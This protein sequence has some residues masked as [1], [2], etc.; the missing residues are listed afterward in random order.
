M[1]EHSLLHPTM[2]DRDIP[3]G[4]EILK[5]YNVAM[6]CVKSY[7]IPLA[8][9][10]LAGTDVKV[11]PVIGFLHGNS[12]INIKAQEAAAAAAS[13]GGHEIGMVVNIGKVFGEDWN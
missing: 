6:T 13:A 4:L 7:L 3:A 5:L 11:F 10:E 2:M 1:I 8:K 12:T 9:R